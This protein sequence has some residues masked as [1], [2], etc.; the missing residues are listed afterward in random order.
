MECH[1]L[2]VHS[3]FREEVNNARETVAPKCCSI[4][5]N[6]WA[7]LHNS[8]GC[9]SITKYF[10]SIFR[11]CCFVAMNK[12]CWFNPL[13]RR[14]TEKYINKYARIFIYLLSVCGKE[15]NFI[16]T[17]ISQVIWH[18]EL[19]FSC[20]FF[21]VCPPK[22]QV[23]RAEWLWSGH[24]AWQF[25]LLLAQQIK[26]FSCSTATACGNWEN[27]AGSQCSAWRNFMFFAPF[28]LPLLL[29]PLGF[30]F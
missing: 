13:L 12:S 23:P 28:S 7:T 16:F 25:G 4:V 6:Q 27:H 24:L 18:W 21:F 22:R 15:E 11:L 20:F 19:F 14:N 3:L 8:L 29:L 5:C 17:C 10:L 26:R 1:L 2:Y 30:F 9:L